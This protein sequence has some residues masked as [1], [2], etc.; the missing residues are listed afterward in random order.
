MKNKIFFLLFLILFTFQNSSADKY[1]FEVSDILVNEEGNLI[2]AGTG[3]ISSIEK[4][5][6]ITAET[7]D[8]VIMAIQH[9][10]FNIHGVQ[11]HPES[12]KTKMGIKILK[13]FIKY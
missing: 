7:D 6:E 11:F 1:T 2:I 4:D 10:Q 8:G 12:I 13:N 3:K 5:L 9:K